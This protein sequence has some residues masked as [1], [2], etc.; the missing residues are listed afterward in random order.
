M[1]LED[2]RA[3]QVVDQEVVLVV[4]EG[5]AVGK[6]EVVEQGLA[7]LGLGVVPVEGYIECD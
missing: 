4:G 1:V 3:D 6:V 2:P 5:D 7:R